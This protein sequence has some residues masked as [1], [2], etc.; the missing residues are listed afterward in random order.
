MQVGFS[1]ELA[2]G[3]FLHSRQEMEADVAE[4]LTVAASGAGVEDLLCEVEAE[5]F[6]VGERKQAITMVTADNY[7]SCYAVWRESAVFEFGSAFKHHL[8]SLTPSS[9]GDIH[10]TR[11]MQP[12]FYLPLLPSLPHL[13]SL[14]TVPPSVHLLV[15]ELSSVVD[16]FHLGVSLKLP[17]AELQKIE[18]DHRKTDRCKIEMLDWW[19]RNT[20][21]PT[22]SAIVMALKGIKM[23]AL[24]QNIV[25]KY[26]KHTV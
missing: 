21:L 26:G 5:L 23:K 6:L 14:H 9:T 19:L 17:V 20:D 8:S 2:I 15:S 4:V 25:I 1:S 10:S 24:A 16:W 13:L 22:W 7:P 18:A 3:D 12:Y 11:Y